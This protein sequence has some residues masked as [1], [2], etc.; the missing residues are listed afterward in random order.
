MPQYLSPG[1]YVEEVPPQDRP[2]AGVG[3]STAA[4]VG[5]VPDALTV[6]VRAVSNE[7]IGVG[8]GSAATFEL[9]AGPVDTTAGTFEIRARD[10]ETG[11]DATADATLSNPDDGPAQVT[12][13]AAPASGALLTGDYALISTFSPTAD[14]GE[15]RLCT[16]WADFTRSFGS[17]STDEGH[18]RLA[19]AVYGFFNNGGTRCYV[20]RERSEAAISGSALPKLAAY[21]EPAIVAVPGVTSAAVRDAVIGHC[22]QTG[23]RFAILDS[24]EVVED[25]DGNLDLTLLDPANAANLLPP[26]S[27]HAA[28]YFPWIRAFDPPTQ[29]RN[30]RSDGGLF[31]PPSGH[32]AGLYAHVDNARG[33]HKAPANEVVRGALGLKY[34]IS[35]AQHDGLN[36]QGV[37]VIRFLN[38]NYRVWGARTAGGDANGAFKYVNARRLFL[39]LA[40]SLDEG[41]QYAVF[42]PNGPPLWS[43]LVRNISAFL[44]RVWRAGALFGNTPQEAFFVK[45]DAELNPPGVRDAGQV[46]CEVGVAIVRPAEFV[47]IRIS[48]WTAGS[49]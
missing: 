16:T 8:D 32:V 39:Y 4:F 2:I 19:H 47:I 34:A 49:A 20:V 42:E 36:P 9:A 30:Q 37:N 23:D 31:V 26:N 43:S 21:D 3:T 14:P 46:I 22:L 38:G 10:P 27:D 13:A 48:Q 12:F 6:P 24:E 18:N 40:E 29:I 33:V 28:F 17:F 25:D 45:C 5:V 7:A 35:K 44:M 41:T 11:Q 1:V 15:P